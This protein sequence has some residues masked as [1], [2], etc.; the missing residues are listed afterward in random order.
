MWLLRGGNTTIQA[1]SLRKGRYLS[2]FRNKLTGEVIMITDE[3]VYAAEEGKSL[4]DYPE[5]QHNEIEQA[6]DILADE[7]DEKYI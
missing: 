3:E 1:F 4:D 5:W 2:F 7:T 6:E